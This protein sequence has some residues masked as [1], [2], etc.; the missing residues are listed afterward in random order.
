MSRRIGVLGGTFDPIHNG[1]TDLAAAAQ[2][3]LQLTEVYVVPANIPP[4]RPQPVASSFHR[5]AMVALAIAGK[6]GWRACD[7]E[8]QADRPSYTSTT[9]RAFHD[10]GYH[11]SELFFL[12]GADTFTEIETWKDY[13]HILDLAHFAV[14]SRPG[15]PAPELR[16]LLPT[17]TARMAQPPTPANVPADPVIFLIDRQTAD[18][19]STAIRRR[20]ASN[21]PIEGLVAPG[22]RQHIEQHGL[23]RQTEPDA[24]RIEEP[25]ARVAGR[26]HG[27]SG[28]TES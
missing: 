9:L 5:F 28:Q 2:Q 12:T 21:Q 25:P 10:L 17:L 8:L 4:H 20:L 18:V 19:S 22:V 13:P 6:N 3:A 11:G 26:V 15:C 7:L 27:Q 16:R 1:H 24:H 23:Y 14:V